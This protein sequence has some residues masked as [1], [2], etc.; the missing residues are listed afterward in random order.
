MGLTNARI[1][2]VKADLFAEDIDVP[3]EAVGW[4]EERL[5]AYIE[6]GGVEPT[7]VPAGTV[8]PVPLGRPT[9]VACLHGTAGNEKIFR[10]QLAKL[11]A[12]LREE[13]VFEVFEGSRVIEPGNPHGDSMRKYFGQKEVLREY[14]PALIDADGL[15]IYEPQAT[16]DAVLDLESRISGAGGCDALLGFSQGANFISM[17][18]ARHSSGIGPLS[19]LRCVI[20]LAPAR[21]GWVSQPAWLATFARPIGL[22]CLVV[23]GASDEAAG[24]GPTEVAA[25]FRGCRYVEHAEG[26]RPLPAERHD[27]EM[28]MEAIRKFLHEHCPR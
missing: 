10:I 22:P 12:S 13:I 5:V 23:G 6:R 25:L 27:A 4:S 8:P 3:A 15:R 20:L 1:A 17:L 9:R 21:P 18:A 11:I 26:H 2:E 24:T 19:S 7:S 14:A 28:V 16:A